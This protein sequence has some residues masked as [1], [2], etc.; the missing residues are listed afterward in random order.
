M[1]HGPEIAAGE[2]GAERSDPH[3]RDV[4]L[5]RRLRATEKLVGRAV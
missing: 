5:E 4:L 3:Y 1:L 2:P